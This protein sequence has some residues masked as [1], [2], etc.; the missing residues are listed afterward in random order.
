MTLE[1]QTKVIVPG[2][3]SYAHIFVPH[4][5]NSGQEPKYSLSLIIDKSDKE[6]LAKIQ[7]AINEAIEKGKETLWGGK[8]PT[9]LK[10]PLRDGDI[11]RGDDPAYQGAYFINANSKTEP[12]VVLRYRDPNTGMGARAT[13]DDVYSGCYANVSITFYPFDVNGNRGVA[14]GLGN[15]QKIKDGERFGG[16]SSADSEFDFEDLETFDLNDLANEDDGMFN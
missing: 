7:S 9:N 8:R 1:R 3:L 6:T 16:R 15:V 2:R 12:E 14:A 10:T 13:E 4:A 5:M 11:D